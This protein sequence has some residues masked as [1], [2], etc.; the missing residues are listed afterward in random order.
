MYGMIISDSLIAIF[1]GL[2]CTINYTI[3]LLMESQKLVGTDNVIDR[4]W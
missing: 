1:E 3:L 2:K 4:F